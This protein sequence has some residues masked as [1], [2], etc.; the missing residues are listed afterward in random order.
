MWS[1]S[2]PGGDVILVLGPEP[3]IGRQSV[4]L[5]S[6]SDPSRAGRAFERFPEHAGSGTL[7]AAFARILR[8]TCL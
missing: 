5:G 3:I 7:L 4:V 1:A 8:D 6:I 2:T